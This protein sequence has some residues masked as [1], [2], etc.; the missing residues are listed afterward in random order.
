MARIVL[1][2]D[3]I[4]AGYEDGVRKILGGRGHDVFRVAAGDTTKVLEA[5]QAIAALAPDLVHVNA[6]LHDL[7]VE[8]T[9]GAH[10]VEPADYER[11]V[12][13][14][15]RR[16]AA[17]TSARVVFAKTTP[18]I[19]ERHNSTKPFFRYDRDV[20]LYNEIAVRA[21]AAAGAAIDDLNRVVEE[22]CPAK[23]LEADGVH[24]TGEA[25]ALLAEKVAESVLANL[26]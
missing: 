12:P 23:C 17:E 13:E 6:G 20:A 15:F 22:A 2:G 10:Q 1:V 9:T 21:A 26:E 16:L 19:D 8:K 11:K 25:N 24:M 5:I 14:I 18:V 7:K 4:S 3:S